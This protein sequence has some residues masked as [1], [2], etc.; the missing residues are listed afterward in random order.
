C[1]HV[2]CLLSTSVAGCI[3]LGP[4]ARRLLDLSHCGG[5]AHM[6]CHMISAE[7]CWSGG[8]FNGWLLTRCDRHQGI[9]P[10][11]VISNPPDWDWPRR[12][13][14]RPQ[15]DGEIS[16]PAQADTVVPALTAL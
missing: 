6:Q 1:V 5:L 2:P 13:R 16:P 9:L 8:G 14:Q 12:G 10:E 4:P 7:R 11:V 3:P 15:S